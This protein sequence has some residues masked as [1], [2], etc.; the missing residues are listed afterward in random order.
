MNR[1]SFRHA[2]HRRD[3]DMSSDQNLKNHRASL[4]AR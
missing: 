4:E 2:I 3:I 1:S